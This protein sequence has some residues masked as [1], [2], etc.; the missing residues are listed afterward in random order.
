MT[1]SSPPGANIAEA[2]PRLRSGLLLLSSHLFSEGFLVDWLFF[3]CYV[4]PCKIVAY[5]SERKR[6]KGGK[7]DSSSLTNKNLVEFIQETKL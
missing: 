2:G 5:L 6:A 3:I 4:Y 1:S 7:E